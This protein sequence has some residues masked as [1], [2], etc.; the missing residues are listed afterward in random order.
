MAAFQAKT[1]MGVDLGEVLAAQAC[2]ELSYEI[3][4]EI[5]KTL[6]ENATEYAD[7]TWNKRLPLGVNKRD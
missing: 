2:G 5:V 6:Y 1:E 4:T 7:L 3:D